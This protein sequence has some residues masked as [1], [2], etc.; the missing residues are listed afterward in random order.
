MK[1]PCIAEEVGKG[2]KRKAEDVGVCAG[3]VCAPRS[4]LLKVISVGKKESRE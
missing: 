2:M 3:G 1:D 4:Q